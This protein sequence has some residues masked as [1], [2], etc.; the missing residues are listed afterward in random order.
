MPAPN[1]VTARAAS[2]P[3]GSA[4]LGKIQASSQR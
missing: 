2:M 4:M 3:T 1:A